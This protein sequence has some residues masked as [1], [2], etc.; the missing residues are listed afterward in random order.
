MIAVK[1]EIRGSNGNGNWRSYGET[2]MDCLRFIF[3]VRGSRFRAGRE[4][5]FAG[6][7]ESDGRGDVDSIFGDG[8]PQFV[9]AGMDA[10]CRV[11]NHQSQELYEDHRLWLQIG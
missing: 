2:I 3:L 10:Q 11:A 9:R 8:P 7:P 1:S 5:C 4:N 6:R